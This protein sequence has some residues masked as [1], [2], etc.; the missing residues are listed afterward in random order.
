M[1]VD[2]CI[3]VKLL[4]REPDSEFFDAELKG[5]PL[6]S[7]ELAYT[8]VCSALLAKE[9]A[10]RLPPADRQR[11][12]KQ[13]QAWVEAEEVLLLPLDQTVLRKAAR[14]LEQCHPTVALRELDA[15]HLATADLT[16]ETPLC[17]TDARLREAAK[18]MKLPVFPER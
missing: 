2:T 12:W 5:Q 16:N 17:T 14:Q 8:E 18:M 7:S 13:F 3:L 9:R 10:G 6:A 15:I 11:A 4:T 1:Y